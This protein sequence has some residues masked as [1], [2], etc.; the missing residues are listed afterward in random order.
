MDDATKHHA[1]DLKDIKD[2][3]KDTGGEGGNTPADT[4]KGDPKKPASQEAK[5][6]QKT[7][8][9]KRLSEGKID[10][11][12]MP[13]N[14]EWL[15]KE[16]E[17]KEYRKPEKKDDL[18]LVV[19]RVLTEREAV[20]EFKEV[21]GNLQKL[22]ISEEKDAQLRKEFED[23]LSEY[24]SPTANQTVRALRIACRL[25]GI[26]DV[27]SYSKERRSKGLVLPALGK[28]RDT[29]TQGKQET[30]IEKRLSGN[31]PPGF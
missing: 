19:N 21:V 26:K 7:A 22:E 24:E 23:L 14:L 28:E 29:S 6:A 12:D 2:D 11:D 10:I 9:L 15:K 27:T 13:E 5:D 3:L 16:P 1:D 25:V 8:W 17:F 20:S 4:D 18:D 31:L 30:E